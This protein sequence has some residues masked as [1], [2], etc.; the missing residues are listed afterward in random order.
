MVM[1]MGAA[2]VLGGNRHADREYVRFLFS[3]GEEERPLMFPEFPVQLLDDRPTPFELPADVILAQ[4]FV[5]EPCRLE[6]TP[7]AVSAPAAKAAKSSGKKSKSSRSSSARARTGSHHK[8]GSKDKAPPPRKPAA[9]ARQQHSHRRAEEEEG[10]AEDEDRKQPSGHSSKYGNDSE[11]GSADSDNDEPRGETPTGVTSMASDDEE[12]EEEEED[13]LY[14][15][16]ESP[17]ISDMDSD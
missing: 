8:K 4:R 12:E 7:V 1:G 13:K 3:T 15:D 2:F 10:A 16:S 6:R 11:Y 5:P 14:E 9:S 17:E